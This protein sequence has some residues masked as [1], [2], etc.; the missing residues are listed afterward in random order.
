MILRN[1]PPSDPPM[2]WPTCWE[3]FGGPHPNEPPD[4]WPPGYAPAGPWRVC[5][6]TDTGSAAVRPLCVPAES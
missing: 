1:R 6:V 5:C 2:P 3:A 4:E